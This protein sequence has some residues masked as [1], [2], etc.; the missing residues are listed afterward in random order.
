MWLFGYHFVSR[1]VELLWFQFSQM[2]LNF[3]DFIPIWL[4]YLKVDSKSSLML[5]KC[6]F[7]LSLNFLHVHF[8]QCYFQIGLI[9]LFRVAPSLLS[10]LFFFRSAFVPGL[11]QNVLL[12]SK[13]PRLDDFK[14]FLAF[15]V[16]CVFL[17]LEAPCFLYSIVSSLFVNDSLRPV[18]WSVIFWLFCLRR[19]GSL[20]MK[21]QQISLCLS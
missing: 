16:L 11:Q 15:T 13:K 9:S 12:F 17:W 3:G 4:I 1:S 8:Y 18:F 14:S 2:D 20:S 10:M 21:D 6:C 7:V 5:Y 19:W